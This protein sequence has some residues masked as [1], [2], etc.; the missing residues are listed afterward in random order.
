MQKPHLTLDTETELL[1]QLRAYTALDNPIRLRAY[2]L[3]HDAPGLPFREIVKDLGVESGLLAYHVAVL[4][5]ANVI[6]V[7]YQRS[8]RETTAYRLTKRGEEIYTA[9]FRKRRAHPRRSRVEA[10]HSTPAR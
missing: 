2:I 9:M 7:D 5:A 6:Q 8:G 1:D 3:I 10:R 4:K